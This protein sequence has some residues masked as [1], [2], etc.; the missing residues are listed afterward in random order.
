MIVLVVAGELER[1]TAAVR[2]LYTLNNVPVPFDTLVD[3]PRPESSM[4]LHGRLRRLVCGE[5]RS[6]TLY[7]CMLFSM[8]GLTTQML[9]IWGPSV[10]QRLLAPAE[11]R[12]PYA[13]MLLFNLGDTLGVVSSVLVVE[14]VTRREAD[15]A[16]RGVRGRGRKQGGRLAGRR[17]QSR[18]RR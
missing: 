5:L 7:A 3:E 9:D 10:F 11:E 12:L 16:L 2:R 17:A 1:A 8:L 14:R 15:R 13:V 6:Y 4:V 18:R